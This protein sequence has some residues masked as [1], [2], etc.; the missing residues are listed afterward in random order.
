VLFEHGDGGALAT[1]PQAG[2]DTVKYLLVPVDRNPDYLH[3]SSDKNED[4]A[5]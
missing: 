2:A 1:I 5:S 3:L 4:D